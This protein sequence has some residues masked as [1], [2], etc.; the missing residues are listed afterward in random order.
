MA[1]AIEPDKQILHVLDVG[2]KLHNLKRDILHHAVL[3]HR[4]IQRI[5]QR[6]H[7]ALDAAA[8]ELVRIVDHKPDPLAHP[9]HTRDANI[10]PE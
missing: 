8:H 2:I 4:L 9:A 7:L 1:S 3:D 6:L 10:A 5:H